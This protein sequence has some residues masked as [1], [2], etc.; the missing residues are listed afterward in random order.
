MEKR[1]VYATIYGSYASFDEISYEVIYDPVSDEVFR[2]ESI[3]ENMTDEEFESCYTVSTKQLVFTDGDVMDVEKAE[4]NK[5]NRE[6]M[7]E[8]CGRIMKDRDAY[9]QTKLVEMLY[10]E[11]EYYLPI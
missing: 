5:G 7:Q 4:Y 8:V 10:F 6:T 2:D 1:L 11:N 3:R 9:Y